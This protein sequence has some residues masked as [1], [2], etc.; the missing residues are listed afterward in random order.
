MAPTSPKCC[1]Y[2]SARRNE[3]RSSPA[4][5]PSGGPGGPPPHASSVYLSTA[6]MLP[7][8]YSQV[9]CGSG[10][11]GIGIN[12]SICE[13]V[14]A[15]STAALCDEQARRELKTGR[16]R[17]TECFAPAP[18]SSATALYW[19]RSSRCSSTGRTAANSLLLRWPSMAAP[20]RRILRPSGLR[21][22]FISEQGI[23]AVIRLPNVL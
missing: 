12:L 17:D 1:V 16:D 13:A 10:A 19:P 6:S 2:L 9:V 23:E 7:P 5:A 15:T 11:V 4:G 21:R 20:I 3:A 8:P 14:P 22:S 18:R